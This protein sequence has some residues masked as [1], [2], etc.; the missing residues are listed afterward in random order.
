MG[1]I[2]VVDDDLGITRLLERLIAKSNHQSIIARNGFE[3]L[4]KARQEQ[5]NLIIT[6]L[7]MPDM[8]GIELTKLLKSDAQTK[9]IPVIILSGNAQLLDPN[10]LPADALLP[11]PFDL[12]TIYRLFD[13]FL[14]RP[15]G[16]NYNQDSHHQYGQ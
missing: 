2:L 9:H 8:G 14:N 12:Q 3:G 10:D 15:L 5:P 16:D 4:S 7:R 11:K 13:K 6:D 1:K